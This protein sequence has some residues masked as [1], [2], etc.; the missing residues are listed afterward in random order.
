MK[1]LKNIVSIAVL[2]ILVGCEHHDNGAQN[3]SLSS[4]PRKVQAQS[5]SDDYQ[6]TNTVD[7]TT[8]IPPAQSEIQIVTNQQSEEIW[9]SSGYEIEDISITNVWVD[10]EGTNSLP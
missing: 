2:A 7:S 6:V 10:E 3:T 4:A 8:V 5:N 9:I 1:A